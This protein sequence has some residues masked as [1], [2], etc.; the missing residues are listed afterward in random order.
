[1]P[2]ANSTTHWIETDFKNLFYLLQKYWIFLSAIFRLLLL[3]RSSS[4][5]VHDQLL[6]D[7]GASPRSCSALRTTIFSAGQRRKMGEIKMGIKLGLST[8]TRARPTESLASL[9]PLDE[10]YAVQKRRS[11]DFEA[12][13]LWACPSDERLDG[14]QQWYTWREEANHFSW[15]GGNDTWSSSRSV[16]LQNTNLFY[17]AGMLSRLIM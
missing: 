15:R 5:H 14:R 10:S 4:R 2:F 8:H 12:L 16:C 17:W 9:E 6:G 1:M 3:L 13:N 11:A 7:A